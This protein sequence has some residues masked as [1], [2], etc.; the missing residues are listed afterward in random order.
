MRTSTATSDVV[1]NYDTM[2]SSGRHTLR[3]YLLFRFPLTTPLMAFL[4]KR[5]TGDVFEGVNV[6]DAAEI[7]RNVTIPVLCTGGFQSASFIRKVL[8]EGKCD[9]VSI[10]RPLMANPD[11]VQVFAAGRDLPERPC[12]FCNLCLVNVLEN[13]LGCYDVRRYDGDH[14]TM[15][16][17]LMS[18]FEPGGFTQ[19]PTT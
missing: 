17:E 2:L 13:P 10:A 14:D 16:R 15:V 3:N 1:R 4:W 7:K 12:T 19:G 18:F 8:A 9:G 5:T 11:L 6:A